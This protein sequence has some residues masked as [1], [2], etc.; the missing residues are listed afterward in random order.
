MDYIIKYFNLKYI[1]LDPFFHP[2]FA[3]NE[4]MGDVFMYRPLCRKFLQKEVVALKYYLI[5]FLSVFGMLIAADS[6]LG[7]SKKGR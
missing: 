7:K 5:G 6:L 3:K 4:Q 2:P 1:L